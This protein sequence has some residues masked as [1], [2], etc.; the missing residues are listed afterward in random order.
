VAEVKTEL[1]QG[2]NLEAGAVAEPIEE[3]WLLS[4]FTV[5]LLTQDQP[6]RGGPT[7]NGLGHPN[8]SVMKKMSYRVAY[9][10]M[11]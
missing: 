9:S 3:C 7:H 10:L 1:K 6:S 8:Q 5:L 4:S 2:R 11:L